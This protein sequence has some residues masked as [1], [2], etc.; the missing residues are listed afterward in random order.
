MGSTSLAEGSLEDRL[1]AASDQGLSGIPPEELLGY[2]EEAAK[3][4]DYLNLNHFD[5]GDGTPA[6]VQHRDLKP[7]N[8]LLMGGG[9][10]VADFGLARILR[11]SVTGHTGSMTLAYAAPEFF[12]GSTTAQSDQYS[13]GI[14]Y[15]ELRTGKLPF[16][17]ATPE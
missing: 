11:G 14:T 8:I 6:G 9:V 2:M 3:G 13:L 10:K 7:Q 12:R 5:F 15:Y 17:G 1:Q 4:I 16:E